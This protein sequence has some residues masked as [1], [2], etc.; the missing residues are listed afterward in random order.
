MPPSG[1]YSSGRSRH[2][3]PARTKGSTQPVI[4]GMPP[5]Q[6]A[7]RTTMQRNS[8]MFAPPD[9]VYP[10]RPVLDVRDFLSRNPQLIAASPEAI[11]ER[12]NLD[13]ADVAAAL[14][15]LRVDGASLVLP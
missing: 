15:A 13:P 9:E 2:A 3:R 7:A 5:G 8:K 14:E 12:L 11:A 4:D 10:N 6:A 1:Y